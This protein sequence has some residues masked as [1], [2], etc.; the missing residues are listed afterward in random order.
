[1]GHYWKT[2]FA[3][4]FA[5]SITM[6]LTLVATAEQGFGFGVGFMVIYTLIRTVF[7][8]GRLV[9]R[10]DLESQYTADPAVGNEKNYIPSGTRVMAFN[11]AIVF[12]NAYRIK[13]DIMD[14][15]QTYHT[16]IPLAERERTK[17]RSWSDLSEQHVA[18]LRKKAKLAVPPK[19]IPRIRVLILDFT[20]VTFIDT[21][22]MQMLRDMKTGLLVYGGEDVELRF[23]GMSDAVKKRFERAGWE[24]AA[25]M[26]AMKGFE[27]G[28][29]VVFELLKPA[30]E[31]PRTVRDS[32]LD[33]GF[34][35][36]MMSH[37]GSVF[38]GGGDEENGQRVIVTQVGVKGGRAFK[39]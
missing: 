25:S 30:I 12:L 23:V 14:T 28:K 10:F 6:Q 15:V 24:L 7:A 35:N 26:E 5:F 3:D 9:T 32:G 1:M 17:E 39:G 31:A 29:D 16:G 22:G 2:S 13:Q 37:A 18:F 19:L 20:Q 36:I 11:Q 34:G 21:T 27:E 33:F 8:R 4:F 38:E